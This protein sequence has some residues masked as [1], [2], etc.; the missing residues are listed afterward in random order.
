MH[1]RFRLPVEF[2]RRLCRNSGSISPRFRRRALE[3]TNAS[4]LDE[5]LF[6]FNQ[7]LQQLHTPAFNPKHNF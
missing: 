4:T 1:S 2:R 7:P 5:T 3:M 6:A